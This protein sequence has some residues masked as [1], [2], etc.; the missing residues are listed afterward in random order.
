MKYL[1]TG[2]TGHLGQNVLNQLVALVGA[3]SV[4]AAV[5]TPS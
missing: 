4:T 1:I 3:D 5:H 2:A